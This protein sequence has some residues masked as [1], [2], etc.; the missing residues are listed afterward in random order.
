MIYFVL[1]VRNRRGEVVEVLRRLA[2]THPPLFV[3]VVDDGSSDGTS[4]EVEA[5]AGLR[6][7]LRLLQHVRPHGLGRA[8]TAG[9][10]QA[11]AQ[12]REA[13]DVV[14]VA[15]LPVPPDGEFLR[16]ALALLEDGA[17]MVV[18]SRFVPGALLPGG[19]GSRLLARLGSLLLRVLFPVPGLTDYT[20]LYRACRLDIL[21]RAYEVHGPRLASRAGQEGL[22]ELTVRLARAGLRVREIPLTVLPADRASFWSRF[23]PGA[24]WRYARM[25]AGLLR[26]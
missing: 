21:R 22:A 3:I 2:E 8:V 6:G 1:P 15:A 4:Q 11:V 16:P 17:D 23:G 7:R 13:S 18:A 10:R 5:F 14:L 19:P 24:L 20:S 26:G 9:L 25:V 12:S